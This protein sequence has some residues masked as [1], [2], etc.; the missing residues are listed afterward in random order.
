MRSFIANWSE[1]S[2]AT[3]LGRITSRGGSGSAT[4]IAGEGNW[5]QI[6]DI[7]TITYKIF[8]E[9]TNTDVEITSGSVTIATSVLDVPITTD[10]LWTQ[11]IVGYNFIHDLPS[12]SFPV[13]GRRYRVEYTV[14]CSDGT[15]FHGTYRGKALP[16]RSS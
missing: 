7:S 12:T 13:G 15:K 14:I 1:D 8:D 6:D 2:S 11:D 10:V 4:G 5:L 16:I 9:T 3:V